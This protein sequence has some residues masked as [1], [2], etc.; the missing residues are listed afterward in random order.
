MARNDPNLQRWEPREATLLESR[1]Q[2]A[3]LAVE[4]LAGRPSGSTWSL[5][6]VAVDGPTGAGGS[7]KASGSVS[8]VGSSAAG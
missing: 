6:T 3:A 4:G 5:K 1:V 8:G 7:S 2:T